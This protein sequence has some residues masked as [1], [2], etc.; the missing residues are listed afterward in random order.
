[1]FFRL[2]VRFSFRFQIPTKVGDRDGLPEKKII[3]GVLKAEGENEG[4]G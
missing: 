3:V 1:M 2:V 4:R